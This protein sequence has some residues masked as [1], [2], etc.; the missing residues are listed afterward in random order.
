MPPNPS[1][2]RRNAGTVMAIFKVGKYNDKSKA[3][4]NINFLVP[5]PN[6]KA[7][8]KITNPNPMPERNREIP[9][10][11]LIADTPNPNRQ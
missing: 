4:S 10:Q 5:T 1:Q 9:I 7:Q 11:N 8:R 6:P 2:S 3:N